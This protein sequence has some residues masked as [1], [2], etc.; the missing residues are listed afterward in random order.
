MVKIQV[1][2]GTTRENRFSEKPA[3]Y[4]FEE[5]KKKEG[6]E[7]ELIDL[8]DWPLPFF[9]EPISPAFNNGTYKNELATKWAQK[10]A[11]ADGYIIV[12]GEYNHGYPAVLKNA[13]DYV[14][15]EWNK[16][17]VGFVSYGT[18][19]GARSVEQL[20][21]VAIELQLVPIRPA[22]HIPFDLVMKL[23]PEKTPV[24]PELFKSLREGQVDRVEVFLTDL[25][26]TTIALKQAREQTKR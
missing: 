17:A 7:A 8:R 15:K 23:M 21:A 26:W 10:I 11:E 2:I 5:L 3:H 22:I 18:A 25:V 6:V 20:R 24:H 9:D 14:Y 16:K 4:I 13:L 19:G 12:T 1:I